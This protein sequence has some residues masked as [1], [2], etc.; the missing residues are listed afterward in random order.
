MNIMN[1]KLNIAAV[2]LAGAMVFGLNSCK[3]ETKGE[4]GTAFDK[5]AGMD[6]TWKISKFSQVDLNNP[7]REERDLSDFY[8][9]DGQ[10]ALELTFN[11]E[12]RTYTVVPG[13]GINFF[14]ESG[15]W[16]FDN[17]AAPSNLYLYGTDTLEFNLGAMVREFDNNLV[18]QLPRFCDDG[19]G[20]RLETVIYK[21]EFAR[22]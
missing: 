13:P 5:V 12:D 3:P 14:G 8:I 4:L 17:D 22:Q 7:I 20:N 11:K 16:G 6:G 15:T 21:F 9:V 18:I 1:K 19:A 10:E 2:L